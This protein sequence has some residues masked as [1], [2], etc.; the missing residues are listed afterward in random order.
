MIQN[1]NFHTNESQV[2]T[3]SVKKKLVYHSGQINLHIIILN[4][5]VKILRT[6]YLLQIDVTD[7]FH[8]TVTK[9]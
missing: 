1:K 5:F 7:H 4:L 2:N 9:K 6:W 3:V 8:I